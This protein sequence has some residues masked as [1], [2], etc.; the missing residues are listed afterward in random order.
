MIDLDKI[1]REILKIHINKISISKEL[2][3]Y[4]LTSEQRDIAYDKI[5][6][7]LHGIWKVINKKI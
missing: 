1:A 3:T 7:L 6:N 2:D 5:D 4:D